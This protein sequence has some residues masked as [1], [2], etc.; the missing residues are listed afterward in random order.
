MPKLFQLVTRQ[1]RIH[2]AAPGVN[3]APQA[4]DVLETVSGKIRGSIEASDTVVAYK[5]D[6]F[7][8]IPAGEIVHEFLREKNRTGNGHR[9]KFFSRT[10]I[11]NDP[12][13]GFDEFL[14]LHGRNFE[15]CIRFL[16]LREESYD[17]RHN[18]PA[19]ALAHLREGFVGLE[20]AART[21]ADMVATKEGALCSGKKGDEFLH[22]RLSGDGGR[23]LRHITLDTSGKEAHGEREN[24]TDERKGG[25]AFPCT[26]KS[27]T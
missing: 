7:L 24:G 22:G 25:S 4:S 23:I 18:Q 11:H 14:S 21:P 16:R 26:P 8:P 1:R 12:R 19:I 2:F 5:D 10:D 13:A 27:S 9:V 20:S 15:P 3:A 6:F 17:I